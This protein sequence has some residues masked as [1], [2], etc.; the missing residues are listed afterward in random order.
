MP[1]QRLG[2]RYYVI[3]PLGGESFGQTYLAQD[4]QR[5]GNPHCVVKQLQPQISDLE[6]FQT[7]RR[8]FDREAQVLYRLGN[9]PQIPG[10]WDHFEDN[11][12]LYL[13]SE[14]IAGNHLSQEMT[15]G[16]QQ[17]EEDV[18]FLLQEILQVLEFVHQQQVIHQNIKPQNLIRRQDGRIV[19]IDFGSVK[20]IGSHAWGMKSLTVNIGTPGYMPAEQAVGK[21]RL[22]SDV[23]AVGMMGIFA[24]TGIEPHQL[25]DD[26]E[27]GEVI[28]HN[29]V[30]V[31][32]QLADVLDKMVL[33]DFRQ[34]YPSATEALQALRN[35]GLIEYYGRSDADRSH[36][37]DGGYD[38]HL[39]AADRAST[40]DLQ[41]GKF[42]SYSKVTTAV[43]KLIKLQSH[44]YLALYFQG[45]MSIKMKRYEDAIAHYCKA[46]EIEPRVLGGWPA[47]VQKLHKLQRSQDAIDLCTR[48]L[49]SLERQVTSSPPENN[50]AWKIVHRSWYKLGNTLGELHCYEK[51]AVAYSKALEMKQDDY[52]SWYGRGYML[53]QLQGDRE[54]IACYEKAIDIKPDFKLAIAGRDR[55]NKKL[56]NWAVV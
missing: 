28:W 11:Q 3:Q 26:P 32:S 51:A 19:L 8:L 1:R 44:N 10:L 35:T 55:I 34:R 4:R 42:Q 6:M 15:P 17:R 18:V 38:L 33:Y 23:Y 43:D 24:L 21:P 13:V 2:E 12:Q 37:V 25:L 5:T 40:E 16:K 30:Q 56:S 22:S 31:S 29:H 45:D 20:L 50:E 53:E 39:C 27:T 36:Q 54:A 14:F 7:V 49:T 47:R 46:I 9:H 48:V 52:E 41:S